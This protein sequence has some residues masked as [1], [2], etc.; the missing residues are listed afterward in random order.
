MMAA[1]FA[2]QGVTFLSRGVMTL[3][4]PGAVSNLFDPN[5]VNAAVGINVI[6]SSI[7][8]AFGAGAMVTRRLHLHL[9]HMA[10]HDPL[11]GLLNRHAVVEAADREMARSVRHGYPLSVLL[12]DID[13][14]KQVN[15]THG[16]DAGD[17]VLRT[18]AAT[19]LGALRRDDVLGRY[20]GEE[21]LALLPNSG[22]EAALAVA[23]RIRAAVG[24]MTVDHG[25]HTI[26]V[27]VSIGVAE[28]AGGDGAW[29]HVMQAADT[30][31][32][33]AK[34]GGRNRVAG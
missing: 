23:E 13:H 10:S 21:F 18:F 19:V 3:L 28:V 32:Y 33:A 2:L 4:G 15:D 20:G 27:T 29:S 31:L 30:A 14:F 5:A 9:D 25:G 12:L 1:V 6:I 26:A 34:R 8:L 11:T 22:R 7:G 16:H 17:A 24:A